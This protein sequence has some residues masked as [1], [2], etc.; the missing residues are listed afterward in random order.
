MLLQQIANSS[1]AT[2]AVDYLYGITMDP[3]GL[4]AAEDTANILVGELS[5]YAAYIVSVIFSIE[6]AR[7]S[8]LGE[9]IDGMKIGKAFLLLIVLINYNEVVGQVNN[10][11]NGIMS[12][13]PQKSLNGVMAS[14]ERNDWTAWSMFN[15]SFSSAGSATTIALLAHFFIVF[16]RKITLLFLYASGPVAFCFGMIPGFGE[17]M[18]KGWFRNYV[19]VQCWALTLIILDT[20]FVLYLTNTSGS[21]LD[22]SGATLSYLAFALMYFIVPTLTNKV[23]GS[24]PANNLM[25]KMV[26][27]ATGA[28]IMATRVISGGTTALASKATKTAASAAGSGGSGLSDTMKN[29]GTAE[30]GSPTYE[31]NRNKTGFRSPQPQPRKAEN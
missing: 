6:I 26:G 16:I 20:L 17:G 10:L 12:E 4:Q 3:A 28:A 11:F 27:V 21:V 18:L 25:S 8:F 23:I 14:A 1:A 29:T 5:S 19:A 7:S 2:S 9:R 24:A 15:F 22:A 31:V 13:L 30:G